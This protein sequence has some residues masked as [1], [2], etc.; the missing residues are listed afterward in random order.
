MKD[1]RKATVGRRVRALVR[2][3]AIRMAMRWAVRSVRIEDGDLVVLSLPARI[4]F[5]ERCAIGEALGHAVGS[6]PARNVSVLMLPAGS[7]FASVPPGETI[8]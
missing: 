2:R 3:A 8:L 6:H 7:R 5:A 4:G 1:G